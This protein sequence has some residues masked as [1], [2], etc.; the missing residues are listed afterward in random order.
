MGSARAALTPL[1][2]VPAGCP[3]LWPAGQGSAVPLEGAP[4]PKLRAGIGATRLQARRLGRVRLG[5]A[6]LGRAG[7][8]RLLPGMEFGA[9]LRVGRAGRK[10]SGCV[11][12]A[13]GGQM[14]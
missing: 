12:G 9:G 10:A 3:R 4:I 8:P 7:Q 13:E 5:R 6:G 11:V 2:R 14:W 1:H